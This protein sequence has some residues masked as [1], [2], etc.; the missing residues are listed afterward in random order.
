[1]SQE[2]KILADNGY[3]TKENMKMLEEEK[4]DGYVPDNLFRKRGVRFATADR[5]KK[6]M[7]KERKRKYFAPSDFK[8]DENGKVICPAGNTLYLKNSHLGLCEIP[9]VGE[10]H[11]AA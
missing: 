9:W 8:R 1:M 10:G 4:I 7:K 2:T 6:L 11:F 5:H 3:D